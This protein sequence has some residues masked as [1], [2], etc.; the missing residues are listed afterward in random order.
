MS[1]EQP[2]E[3]IKEE[4]K[5]VIK[6]DRYELVKVPTG[7]ALAIQT[8]EGEYIGT[9]MATVEILNIVKSIEKAVAW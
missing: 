9:E 6:P 8:P 5:E 4:I 7:E 2:A 3:E 1:E